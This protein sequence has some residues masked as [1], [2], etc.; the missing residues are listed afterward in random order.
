MILDVATQ[1]RLR[2]LMEMAKAEAERTESLDSAMDALELLDEMASLIVALP[3]TVHVEFDWSTEHG[4]CHDCGLP[5]AYIV[6]DA[7]GP[8][9]PLGPEHLRCCVCAAQDAAQGEHIE[10]LFASDFEVD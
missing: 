6:P 10:Y 1:S 2:R 9:K 4:A 3:T 7:Y 8:D 5:A